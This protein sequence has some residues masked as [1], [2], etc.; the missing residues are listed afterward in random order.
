M[1]R[2]SCRTI[3]APCALTKCA[4]CCLPDDL[5]A[6]GT[7]EDNIGSL[8]ATIESK[9]KLAYDDVLTGWKAAAGS[10]T[11]RRSRSKLRC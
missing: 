1:R 4:R 3:S 9:A 11:A 6:D 5:A 7:I 2:A 8:A 10:R